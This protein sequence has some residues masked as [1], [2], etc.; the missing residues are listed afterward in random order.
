[1]AIWAE[2][3][4][5]DNRVFASQTKLGS[6]MDFKIRSSI[7]VAGERRTLPATLALAFCAEQHFCNHVWI[8]NELPDYRQARFGAR[9]GSL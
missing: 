6:V 8:P 5:V 1:M 2:C 9:W 3:N 4:G 7:T